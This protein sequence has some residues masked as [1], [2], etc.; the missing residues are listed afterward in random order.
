MVYWHWDTMLVYLELWQLCT[1]VLPLLV[2]RTKLLPRKVLLL[3]GY[4]RFDCSGSVNWAIKLFCVF[5]LCADFFIAIGGIIN[6]ISALFV[7]STKVL[8]C[9]Y[10]SWGCV[11]FW[12]RAAWYCFM[13]VLCS[14]EPI[15][16]SLTLRVRAILLIYFYVNYFVVFFPLF[17]RIS[18]KKKNLWKMELLLCCI[19]S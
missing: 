4:C 12:D 3:E 16:F 6:L 18:R 11:N 14:I 10:G 5:F 2:K 1:L 9:V 19:L 15:L 8:Y 7:K 13:S 17:Y